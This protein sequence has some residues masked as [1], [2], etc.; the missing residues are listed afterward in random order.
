MKPGQRFTT[1]DKVPR[2]SL[3]GYWSKVL[4]FLILG[5]AVLVSG[6]STLDIPWDADHDDLPDVWELQY[7]MN[8]EDPFDGEEDQDQDGLTNRQEFGSGTNPLQ[9]ESNLR[10]RIFPAGF[11][12]HGAIGFSS[13]AGRYYAIEGRLT[14]DARNP[15]TVVTN[16]FALTN[17]PLIVVPMAEESTARYYRVRVDVHASVFDPRRHD[18]NLL[19]WWRGYHGISESNTGGVSRMEDASGHGHDFLQQTES[20]QPTRIRNGISGHDTIRFDGINDYMRTDSL[21]VPQPCS[22]YMLIKQVDWRPFAR[23]LNGTEQGFLYQSGSSPFIFMRTADQIGPGRFDLEVGRFGILFMIWNGG[24]TKISVDNLHVSGGQLN[25]LSLGGLVLGGSTTGSLH[26]QLEFAEMIV[27]Q[28]VDTEITRQSH[29]RYLASVAGISYRLIVFAGNSLTA[30]AGLGERS[31]Y[32]FQVITNLLPR[33]YFASNQGVGGA[34]TLHLAERGAQV[35][36]LYRSDHVENILCAWEITNHLFQGASAEEAY[37]AFVDYCRMRRARGW[38]VI[39]LTVLPRTGGFPPETFESDRSK[40]NEWM[41]KDYS[42]FADG[43]ADVGADP[44]IGCS[45]CTTNSRYFFDRTHLTA[46]GYSRV[47][48]VVHNAIDLLAGPNPQATP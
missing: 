12:N 6:A 36:S 22:M 30:G 10:I 26:G 23:L 39:A 3:H 7:G 32:S 20:A 25:D 19:A 35:D 37:A 8:P 4:I 47:A 1:A 45:T 48:R 38:R 15:W 5:G 16:V 24:S 18:T 27:R 2:M 34:T 43:L 42:T 40:I 28:G 46:E 21:S 9:S 29:L 14:M 41:R 17:D 44:E 11:G 33:K 31:L 13:V